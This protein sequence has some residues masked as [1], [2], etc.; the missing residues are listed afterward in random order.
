MAPR[1]RTRR[2]AVLD[3]GQVQPPLAGAQ[4]GDVAHHASPGTLRGEVPADQ[5]RP[6]H[7]LLAGY[8]RGLIGPGLAGPQPGFAHQVRGQAHAARISLPVELGSHPPAELVD[9]TGA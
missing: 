3:D 2:G 8:G 4:A 9:A 6:G 7:R 1:T 5:V